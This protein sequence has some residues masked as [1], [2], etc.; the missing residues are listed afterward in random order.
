MKQKYLYI[1]VAVLAVLHVSVHWGRVDVLPS[2]PSPDAWFAVANVSAGQGRQVAL[3]E[4]DGIVAL[5][6]ERFADQGPD[7]RSRN[8]LANMGAPIA[9][10]PPVPQRMQMEPTIR[11]ER[12][13]CSLRVSCSTD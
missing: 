9:A 3:V 11:I 13:T 7:L 2:L 6:Q 10:P 5:M 12:T 8:P 4:G 1:V